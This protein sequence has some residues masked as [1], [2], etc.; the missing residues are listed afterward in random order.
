MKGKFDKRKCLKCMYH[1]EGHIGYPVRVGDK[2]ITVY[3]N[4]ASVTGNTCLKQKNSH[5][6]YD[7]RG[8]IHD[9][10]KLFVEGVRKED[11]NE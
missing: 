4:Y 10:C 3:C 9:D 11:V 1:G 5:E 2:T 6:S 8:E 7:T